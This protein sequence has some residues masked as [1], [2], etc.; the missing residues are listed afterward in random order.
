MQSTSG[1]GIQDPSEDI[2]IPG[3][4]AEEFARGM[5]SASDEAA[6]G[7]K[8]ILDDMCHYISA[9]PFTAAGIALATG[10]VL[11]RMVR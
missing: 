11:G 8:E 7:E 5:S 10:V 9:H 3:M 6:A 1:T 2:T 4:P